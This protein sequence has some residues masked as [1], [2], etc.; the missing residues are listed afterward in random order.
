MDSFKF[1]ISAAKMMNG[2]AEIAKEGNKLLFNWIFGFDPPNNR[3]EFIVLRPLIEEKIKEIE[4]L[5]AMRPTTPEM[6]RTV[7]SAKRKLATARKVAKRYEF[8]VPD[9]DKTTKPDKK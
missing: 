9:S 3:D 7:A 1:L 2:V 4:K 8:P 5:T 6:E